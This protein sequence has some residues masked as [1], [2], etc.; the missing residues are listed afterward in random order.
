MVQVTTERAE[1][2]VLPIILRGSVLVYRV[3]DVAEEI[4]L[5]AVE[6]ILKEDR[7]ARSRLQFRRQ[8]GQSLFMR[9]PPIRVG[10]GES[11]IVIGGTR[12]K[13]D[14]CAT[15]WDYGVIS[16][17][18]QMPIDPGTTWSAL[19]SIAEY[20]NLDSM[21]GDGAVARE[22]GMHEVDSFARK[23]SQ[24][25]VEAIQQALK[26]PAQREIFEDYVIYQLEK[27]E[28][29]QNAQEFLE[30]ADLPS[31]I[32]SEGRERLG[33]KSRTGVLEN[34]YQYAEN[35]L[36]VID[37]NSA[38][39]L[40][41]SGQR[42]I[43]DVLEFA[44]THLLEFRYYDDLLDQRLARLYETLQRRRESSGRLSLASRWRA[45]WGLRFASVSSDANAR[46]IEFSE[47]IERIDNSL[48]VVGD[49]YLAV[50]FRAAIRRF[51]I[52]DWQQSV[53]RKMN[54]LA[55]VSELLQG[56]VNVRRGHTLEMII[57]LLIAFEIVS[58]VVRSM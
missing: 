33:E 11:E 35:D 48:K 13:V 46:Y 57:I 41:P 28:G 38:V 14:V 54:V 25:L 49:F 8:A 26:S 52:P 22:G 9:N 1:E 4:D 32:L 7:A 44:L 19:V 58:A 20:L 10:L 6:R 39:V 56:E 15:L 37:W 50:I 51:R 30:R 34:S 23:R 31:L 17:V 21:T 12:R 40:E 18:I 29:V 43:A 16:V 27:L 42:D 53:V 5:T 24:E 47:F 45:I 55:R 2:S 3:F 36:T